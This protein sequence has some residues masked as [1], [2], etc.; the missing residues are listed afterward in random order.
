MSIMLLAIQSFIQKLPKYQN[1]IAHDR[2]HLLWA[3]LGRSL[4]ICF[5]AVASTT[6]ILTKSQNTN[7]VKYF[8]QPDDDALIRYFPFFLAVVM[9]SYSVA[10][11]ID[12]VFRLSD[13]VR[14]IL[15]KE[16]EGGEGESQ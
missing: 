1:V 3:S 9:R 8:S 4:L 16:V 12:I 7:T 11:I 6:S 5:G 10:S 15:L 13:D 14:Y 2:H